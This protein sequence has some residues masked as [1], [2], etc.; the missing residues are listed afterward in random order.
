MEP[1]RAALDWS[2][3]VENPLPIRCGF[4]LWWLLRQNAAAGVQV[5]M[6]TAAVTGHGAGRLV[7]WDPNTVIRAGL[8][9][10]L[11]SIGIR[12]DFAGWYLPAGDMNV[13]RLQDHRASPG[14]KQVLY[15]P[16]P[17]GY[18]EMWGGNHE[19]FEECGRILPAFGA[20]ENRMTL[21]AAAGIG[22]ADYANRHAAVSCAR[23]E[24]GTGWD[25]KLAPLRDLDGATLTLEE[26]LREEAAA[27]PVTMQTGRIGP[28]RP[29]HTF[30]PRRAKA[31]GMASSAAE[32]V[33]LVWRDTS[34]E[35]LVD[36]AFPLDVGPPPEAEFAAAQ[37]RVRKTMPG[38][39]GLYA[40][41]TDLTAEHG[42]NLPKSK[43]LN[44]QILA[45][46][47]DAQA[48]LDAARQLMRV[49]V[50]SSDA[51]AGLDKV[52]AAR[53][54]D[55]HASLYKAVW[56][57]EAGRTDEAQ[58]HLA[59]AAALPGARYLLALQ[60]VSK[61]EF[62]RA[63][64]HLTALLAM[65]SEATFRGAG[66]PGLALLQSGSFVSATRPRLL[67]AIVFQTQG[68]KEAADA[69]LRKLVENDPALIEAWMLLGD[70]ERLKTLT[71]RNESGKAA[72]E[73]IIAAL[74]AGRWDGIGRP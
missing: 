16:N 44:R 36:R 56:L 45:G 23:K 7:P 10:S 6:P 1:G 22:K 47:S 67:L 2:A 71:G 24:D 26:R 58:A 59:K 20:Y 62:A 61:K 25:V 42:L 53:P 41:A 19:V 54:A 3:R 29:F 34:G 21:L 40:E 8:Q 30:L 60:A 33:R 49:E 57:W 46:T 9:D 70:A 63:E 39:A 32:R 64:E 18:I 72:A 31:V 74:T 38:G 52:L 11:F 55:P 65:P 66:D 5:I 69:L 28:A 14:A 4:K 48:L 12:H 50:N 51:L 35:A 15:Q 13:L 68:K 17:G 37:A 27:E 73:R 43:G